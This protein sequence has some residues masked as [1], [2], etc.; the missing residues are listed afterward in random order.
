MPFL[1]RLRPA[2]SEQSHEDKLLR[3]GCRL[4]RH[5]ATVQLRRH[6]DPDR[7]LELLDGILEIERHIG[8]RPDRYS[9]FLDPYLDL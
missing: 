2:R 6:G 7:I 3:L 4:L 5:Q 9:S 1:R 8:R